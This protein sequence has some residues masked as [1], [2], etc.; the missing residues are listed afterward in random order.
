MKTGFCEGIPERIRQVRAGTSQAAFAKRIG[1]DVR[2]VR[3]WEEGSLIPNGTS[4]LSMT[5]SFGVDANWILTGQGVASTALVSPAERVIVEAM[6][7]ASAETLGAVF[8]ALGLERYRVERQDHTGQ[9]SLFAA[10]GDLPEAETKAGEGF[11]RV[12][13]LYTGQ[14]VFTNGV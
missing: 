6:R 7:S 14:T 1:V 8:A 10:T 13:D 11:R 5:E 4:L 2:T 3:R 12:I 9:W